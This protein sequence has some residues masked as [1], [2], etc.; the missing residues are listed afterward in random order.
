[1]NKIMAYILPMKNFAAMI[2]AGFIILYMVTGV[3]FGA[4]Y[5]TDFDYKIPFTFVLQGLVLALLISC[6]WSILFNNKRKSRTF[7]RLIIFAII[8]IGLVKISALALLTLSL[9]WVSLWIAVTAIIT[10]GL[11]VIAILG[12]L[13]FRKEGKRYTEKLKEYQANL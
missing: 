4:I 7:I 3:L 13:F 8:L 5:N 2:F 9:Q 1:M 12:E 6:L 10:V 11:I